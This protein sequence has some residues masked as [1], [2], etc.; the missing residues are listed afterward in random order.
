MPE[1]PWEASPVLA[2]YITN[3]AYPEF[4]KM[5]DSTD[6]ATVQNS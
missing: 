6:D 4:E 5:R 3:P 2:H 1:T